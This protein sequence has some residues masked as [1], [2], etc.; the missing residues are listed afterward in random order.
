MLAKTDQPDDC[1]F[2][3]L[4]FTKSADTGAYR[5]PASTMKILLVQP[6]VSPGKGG[7]Q[8][9]TL[10]LA[11]GLAERG[12]EVRLVGEFF[13]IPEFAEILYNTGISVSPIRIHGRGI[14]P[15]LSLINEA[16]R[17]QPD[18]I[19]SSLRSGDVAAGIAAFLSRKPV[20][21]TV[22]E[23]L[24][25]DNDIREGIGWKG[26]IHK[27]LLRRVFDSIG[28]TS[29]FAS[30]HLKKYTNNPNLN[31]T[32]IPNG[33]D[34]SIFG[35]RSDS[36]SSQ[37]SNSNR[38]IILGA[39]GRIAPEK[40]LEL[41][42]QLIERLVD[43]GVD[44][45]GMIVGDGI[46]GSEVRT[47]VENSP[48]RDQIEFLGNRTDMA[49][50][51]RMFDILVHFGSVEGFGLAIAESMASGIP[52]VAANAGGVAE[53]IDDG[54]DGYLV[55]PGSIDQ[56]ANRITSLVRNPTEYRR[57]SDRARI[58]IRKEFSIEAFVDRYESLY[59]DVV[60]DRSD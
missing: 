59:F 48:S 5:R 16:R 57:I 19:H 39:V 51:Y 54:K 29:N 12:H 32:V 28:V 60:G 55:T 44:A 45:R 43:E 27:L 9:N 18:L 1:E 49:E 58:K 11:I 53:I 6:A 23:K 35:N 42:P 37:N 52:V 46:A 34:V 40:Q 10:R 25:T 20:V 36:D 2:N 15:I 4:L 26:W 21:S 17:F 31:V 8:W 14:K 41:F 47:L 50:V 7:A 22:G 56:Y 30:S 3:W 13:Q 24:P 38:S 33:I